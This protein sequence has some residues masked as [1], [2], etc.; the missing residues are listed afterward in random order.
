MNN[1][2]HIPVLLSEVLNA[3]APT[4]GKCYLDGTFGSGG[5]TRAILEKTDCTV[6]AIDRDP[7]SIARAKI[8]KK[9]F[10]YRKGKHLIPLQGRF[11]E[12]YMLAK[13]A[14]YSTVDGVTLDL[15]FSSIQMDE[16][17]RGFS[18][19]CD[20]PLDMRMESSGITAADLVNTASK[21]KLS[22]IIFYLGEER[23][24]CRIVKAIIRARKIAPIHRTSQLATLVRR[25][26]PY[27]GHKNIDPATRTF[28]ALRIY[29]NNE[30]EEL[31]HG[32][33]AAERLLAPGGKLAVV[34]FHSL[35]DR[36]VKL[37]LR[38]RSGHTSNPSRH[39]LEA[40]AG[41]Y[42][43]L[44][45]TF[46]ITATQLILPKKDEISHNPRARS[47]R[48][49]IAHRTEALPWQSQTKQ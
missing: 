43:G 24:A 40:I 35:E 14:G 21:K 18:F 26:I 49:R 32:L 41:N 8:M 15:G 17:E 46:A 34:S 12:M 33:D 25:S 11:S 42:A 48:L 37:L 4:S 28:Q 16:A 36:K 45:P 31:E 2:I 20:G 1:K 10:D 19:R 13:N 6:L 47:A 39:N 22:D 3:L 27:S 23:Y 7:D 30:L 5:Y 44:L 38:K 9:E 29:V